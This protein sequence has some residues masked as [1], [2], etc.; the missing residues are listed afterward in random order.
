VANTSSPV[1]TPP[2][3]TLTA[4]LIATILPI[5]ALLGLAAGFAS[6]VLSRFAGRRS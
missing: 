4:P 6:P 5:L 2:T 1:A 3:P